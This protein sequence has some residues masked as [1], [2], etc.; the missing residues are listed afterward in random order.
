MAAKKKQAADAAHK[1][2][3]AAKA[4]LNAIGLDS[5]LRT[6]GHRLVVLDSAL[7][8]SWPLS[9]GS[10]RGAH[11]GPDPTKRRVVR[12]LV[13]A[14]DEL[15]TAV[16]HAKLDASSLLALARSFPDDPPSKSSFTTME[17]CRSYQEAEEVVTRFEAVIASAELERSD[18][19]PAP[20]VDQEFVLK[21][22]AEDY[23][24]AVKSGDIPRPGWRDRLKARRTLLKELV[25]LEGLGLV[26]RGER[27]GYWV[28]TEQGHLCVMGR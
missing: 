9:A 18:A 5:D 26:E 23:P 12:V 14:C 21:R 28:C 16:E 25:A 10:I 3:M 6:V 8:R 4:W 20:T 17:Q 1:W 11:L 22:L 7:T 2:R 15:A 27:S 19:K 24:Q 13:R